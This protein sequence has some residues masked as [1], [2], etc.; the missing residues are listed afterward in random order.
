MGSN[1]ASSFTSCLG[2]FENLLSELENQSLPR[3]LQD[4]LSP[5]AVEDE[6]G[7]FKVWAGYDYIVKLMLYGKPN[8][9]QQYCCSQNRT[10]FSRLS[11]ERCNPIARS[12]SRAS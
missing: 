6:L 1:I 9:S 11:S 2:T 7:R 12:N 4:Q 3:N 8:I 5:R 10:Q